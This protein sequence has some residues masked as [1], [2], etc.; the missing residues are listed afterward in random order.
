M[1]QPA[2]GD[3]GGCQNPSKFWFSH[4]KPNFAHDELACGV[5]KFSK[6]D[7][8]AFFAMKLQLMDSRWQQTTKESRKL[9]VC[10]GKQSAKK[11]VGAGGT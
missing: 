3:N 5:R 7:F 1:G 4:N 2:Q 11:K 6:S 9:Y 10:E 8:T